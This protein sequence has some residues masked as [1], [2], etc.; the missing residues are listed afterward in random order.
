MCNVSQFAPMTDEPRL[1]WIDYTSIS[2]PSDMVSIGTLRKVYPD[3]FDVDDNDVRA[4]FARQRSGKPKETILADMLG[5]EHD[6][7][8][9]A[10]ESALGK[11]YTVLTE[12]NDTRDEAAEQLAKYYLHFGLASGREQA[13][14]LI[15][16]FEAQAAAQARPPQAPPIPP[17]RPSRGR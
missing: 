17:T 8:R 5:E 6:L 1:D 10:F 9:H 11:K 15:Q 2:F 16:A 13:E 3:I 7:A 14:Q 12:W 4:F